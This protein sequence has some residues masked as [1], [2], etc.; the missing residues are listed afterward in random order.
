MKL[1]D[2]EQDKP[3]IFSAETYDS[4]YSVFDHYNESLVKALAG[5]LTTPRNI[6][7]LGCGSG[8]FTQ[9]LAKVFTQSCITGIDPSSGML[10]GAKTRSYSCPVEFIEAPGEYLI[11][12][13]ALSGRLPELIVSKSAY[14]HF[15][16]DLPIA[17]ILQQLSPGG[18]FAVFERTE[19]SAWSYPMFDEGREQ[20][21][22]FFAQQ[23]HH[24]IRN[25]NIPHAATSFGAWV[26]VNAEQYFSAIRNMQLSFIWSFSDELIQKW[27]AKA[28]QEAGETVKVFEELRAC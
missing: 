28:Q 21:A 25:G 24:R 22:N 27:A 2:F 3:N 11:Q 9:A 13:V 16:K 10:S 4:F 19:R 17:T 15:E 26:T 5:M 18:C 12:H 23:S 8:L 7:D 6:V 1:S 20:W 14:H